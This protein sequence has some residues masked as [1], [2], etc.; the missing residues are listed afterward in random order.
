MAPLPQKFRQLF[1]EGRTLEALEIAVQLDLKQAEARETLFD[2]TRAATALFFAN[3]VGDGSKHLSRIMRF[4]ANHPEH[5]HERCQFEHH[6]DHEMTEPQAI[7]VTASVLAAEALGSAQRLIVAA[8]ETSGLRQSPETSAIVNDA[9]VEKFFNH[10]LESQRG[11]LVLG[12]YTFDSEAAKHARIEFIPWFLKSLREAADIREYTDQELEEYHR[13]VLFILDG[14]SRLYADPGSDFVALNWMVQY[15]ATKGKLQIGRN[16]ADTGLHSLRFTQPSNIQY[17]TCLAWLCWAEA[18]HRGN[19]LLDAM[20]KMIF[21][22]FARGTEPHTGEWALREIW[23][24]QKIFRSA[25][26]IPI[27]RKFGA[28]RRAF[29]KEYVH[30]PSAETLFEHDVA[31][32]QV[33]VFGAG[34]TEEY[35]AALAK[36]VALLTR[37]P[38]KE[39]A[40]LVSAGASIVRILR[41]SSETPD[42]IA[43]HQLNNA[44]AAVE[45]CHQR[46]FRF[47]LAETPTLDELRTLVRHLP[48]AAYARDL[49][50]TIMPLLPIGFRALDV[51]CET[52]D[53]EMFLLATSILSQPMLAAPETPWP[54]PEGK[55][56]WRQLLAEGEKSAENLG[57]AYAPE[58]REL[59]T[60]SLSRLAA[61]SVK[62]IQASLGD[63]EEALF[64]AINES[65]EAYRMAVT[66]KRVDLPRKIAESEWSSQ[67]YETWRKKFPKPFSEWEYDPRPFAKEV[68]PESE[69]RSA[70]AGLSFL[71]DESSVDLRLFPTAMLLGFVHNLVLSPAGAPMLANRSVDLLPSVAWYLDLKERR[72][73]GSPRKV[74]WLGSAISQDINLN[75]LRSVLTPSLVK[76]GFELINEDAP[77]SIKSASLVVVV[78]HGGTGFQRFFEALSDRV[79]EFSTEAFASYFRGSGCVVLFVCNAGS[80]Q[81]KHQSADSHGLAISMLANDVR[82]VV[83]C[84]WLLTTDSAREWLPAFL[85]QIDQGIP[86]RKAAWNAAQSVRSKIPH[87]CGWAPLH[88]YGNGDFIPVPLIR[89]SRLD[90]AESPR[91]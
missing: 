20:Q 90:D 70:I 5:V 81:V 76:S 77:A 62:M 68:I 14:L 85:A 10:V 50:G 71:E 41:A 49:P 87:W 60:I 46:I 29:L 69:I 64:V 67:N 42:P 30:Q 40:S 65:H 74:A 33:E 45:I 1:S 89:T 21:A 9:D 43:V 18:S 8:R 78:S 88:V 91:G 39:I 79:H 80:A 36:T 26:I 22:V 28:L 84:P 47:L 25:Q 52:G 83:A 56:E 82:V 19:Q 31:D 86:V 57:K 58:H 53:S 37:A 63:G 16:L 59:K 75:L 13:Q 15:W 27:A 4:L 38:A 23:L 2:Q 48:D 32:L 72:W 17:R 6:F 7:R 12:G 34:S 55:S 44:A 66:A 11:T 61:I 73:Q 54:V 35:H 51:A 3:N 24:G